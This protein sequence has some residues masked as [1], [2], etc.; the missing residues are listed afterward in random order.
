MSDTTIGVRHLT[1]NIEYLL[2]QTDAKL[3]HWFNMNGKEARIELEGL[4]A[5]G[6]IKIGSENCT[7]FDPVEGCQ[8]RFH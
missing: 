7:H 8:C 1:T 4:K 5:K 3:G 2:R 6:D